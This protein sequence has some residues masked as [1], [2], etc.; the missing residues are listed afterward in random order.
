M[1]TLIIGNK[2]YSSWSLRG[3][4]ALRH[5]GVDF[6]EVKVWLNEPECKAEILKISPSGKVPAL[7]DGSL[8][9]WESLALCE[10]AAE[11]NPAMWPADPRARAIARAIAAEMHAGFTAL[12]S[13]LPMNLRATGRKVALS[14]AVLA[15]I[16]R[17]EHIWADCRARYGVDGG[18]P[19]L[20]GQWSMADAM[21]A[22]LATRFITYGI[23][24]SGAFDD[25]IATV[26]ADPLFQ[27][28]RAEA[29][30]ETALMADNE[31][32]E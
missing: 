24:R 18:G 23:H 13:A 22:P 19:W 2:N 4:L 10:Y 9:V 16:D 14:P 26:V 29:L 7:R 27:E 32:G 3:W 28:W 1:A 8:V 15:D 5:A 25:Y 6:D 21:Y 11:Q 12:R 30:T 20:F 31:A 17:I